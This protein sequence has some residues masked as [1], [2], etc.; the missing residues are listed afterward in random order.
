MIRVLICDDQ[1][2]VCEGLEAIL[3]DDPEI[4]VVEGLCL[5]PFAL[6]G[7]DEATPY[8]LRRGPSGRGGASTVDFWPHTP[9]ANWALVWQLGS[10]PDK[11]RE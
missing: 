9:A 7:C 8:G 3:S 2:I 1:W 5:Q 10:R 4:Q 11:V 6:V